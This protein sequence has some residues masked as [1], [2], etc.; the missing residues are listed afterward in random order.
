MWNLL[1]ARYYPDL[2]K[3]P[4]VGTETAM[5]AKNAPVDNLLS[6]LPP[7]SDIFERLRLP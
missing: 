5:H 1:C 3:C 7:V 4:H 6:E 2:V